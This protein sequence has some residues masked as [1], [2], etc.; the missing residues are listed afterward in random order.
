MNF[1][2]TIQKELDTFFKL[3]D[4]DEYSI[5]KVTK[6]AFTQAR[7]HLDFLI[8]KRLNKIAADVFYKRNTYHKWHNFRLLAVDGSRV[9]LPNHKTVK[10]EF[11]V[12]QMGPKADSTQSLALISMLYDVLNLI[13]LD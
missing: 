11:G 9:Q 1:R 6:S 2:A 10:E 5:R 7:S 8:F 12:H 13:T 3:V 4:G